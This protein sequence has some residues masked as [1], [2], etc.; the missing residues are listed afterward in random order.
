VVRGGD[1]QNCR[2]RIRRHFNEHEQQMDRVNLA[3][4]EATR[5]HLPVKY[6]YFPPFLILVEL[7]PPCI[8]QQWQ[9]P[10]VDQVATAASTPTLANS[11]VAPSLQP[12]TPESSPTKTPALA[13]RRG[14]RSIVDGFRRRAHPVSDNIDKLTF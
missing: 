5:G 11:P 7:H 3:R 9:S 6:A 10:P 1:I 12:Q 2:D 14:F 8:T 13:T 4:T